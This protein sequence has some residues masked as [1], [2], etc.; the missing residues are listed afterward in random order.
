MGNDTESV[1]ASYDRIAGTYAC[2]YAK[3]LAQ[4]PLDRQ[5]LNRFA[6][7]VKGRGDVCDMGCG[8]G[9]VARYLRDSGVIN[10]FGLDLSPGMVEQ[11]R[12]LNPDITFEVGNMMDLDLQDESLVGIVAFYSIVNIPENLLLSVF[13]EMCRVLKPGG[14]LLLSFHIG[15]EVV[16]PGELL[17]QPISMDFFFFQPAAITNQMEAAGFLVEDVVERAPYGPDV[18]YQSRRAYVFA[19]KVRRKRAQKERTNNGSFD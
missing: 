13:G 19:R 3:E 7:K 15:D 9:H 5:F 17:G 10:A 16:Q 18:E 8:P 1:R 11:A 6:G 14:H 4:K 2:H 12:E